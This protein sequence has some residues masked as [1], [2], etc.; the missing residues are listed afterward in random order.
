MMCIIFVYCW[1]LGDSFFG[2]QN[3]IDLQKQPRTQTSL[4]IPRKW[5]ELGGAR[6][7]RREGERSRLVFLLP[8]VLR[9]GSCP[10]ARPS[11]DE[12]ASEHW[13][14][15][16]LEK[17]CNC[18]AISKREK[19]SGLQRDPESNGFLCSRA[20]FSATSFPGLFPSKF[21][22]EGKSPGNEVVFSGFVFFTFFFNSILSIAYM[23]KLNYCEAISS[24]Y[25]VYIY[26]IIQKYSSNVWPSQVC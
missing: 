22:K 16:D 3:R 20:I 13:T 1:W 11:R 14:V 19:N 9:A 12:A 24:L 21:C 7:G 8:M 25:S 18:N 5:R 26:N 4:L 17:Q 23:C 10:V 15:E 6:K 2:Y